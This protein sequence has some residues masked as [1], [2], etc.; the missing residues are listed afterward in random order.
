MAC[1]S[2]VRNKIKD[3]NKKNNYSFLFSLHLSFFRTL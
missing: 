2:R 3:G 1:A